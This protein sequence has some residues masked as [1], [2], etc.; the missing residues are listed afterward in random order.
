MEPKFF[1]IVLEYIFC[2]TGEYNMYMKQFQFSLVCAV[3]SGAQNCYKMWFELD[4]KCH[5]TSYLL[6][7]FKN[8]SRVGQLYNGV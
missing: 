8:Y 1:F 3:V 6:I 5:I 7:K 4:L 2:S